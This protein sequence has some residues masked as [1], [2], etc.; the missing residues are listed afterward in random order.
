MVAALARHAR[1]TILTTD[2][3]FDAIPDVPTE[4]W[5]AP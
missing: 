1:L 2:R 4:N 5:M 3:D